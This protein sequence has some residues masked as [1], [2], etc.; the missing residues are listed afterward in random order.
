MT[1][2]V[3]GLVC[4]TLNTCFKNIYTTNDKIYESE[5]QSQAGLYLEDL[6][7]SLP[8]M[9]FTAGV[10]IILLSIFN[11]NTS[12]IKPRQKQGNG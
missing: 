3:K 8:R 4:G 12:Y 6:K 2:C 9:S 1:D 11:W 5:I 10:N 7:R